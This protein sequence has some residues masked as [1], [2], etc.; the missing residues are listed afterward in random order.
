MLSAWLHASRRLLPSAVP[1]PRPG[2]ER[3]VSRRSAVPPQCRAGRAD[4]RLREGAVSCHPAGE[5]PQPL[6]LLPL[7]RPTRGWQ[8]SQSH[9]ETQAH[10]AHGIGHSPARV[11]TPALAICQEPKVT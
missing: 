10:S 11:A 9:E 8:T 3:G 2:L 5:R 1:D 4:E 7:R 6:A